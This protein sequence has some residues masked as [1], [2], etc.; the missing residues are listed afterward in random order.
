MNEEDNQIRGYCHAFEAV[1]SIGLQQLY[2]TE[3]VIS[4]G[5]NT[6]CVGTKN[7][8]SEICWDCKENSAIV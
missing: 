7:T 8:E 6:I 2:W 3:A 4:I 1:I 5:L